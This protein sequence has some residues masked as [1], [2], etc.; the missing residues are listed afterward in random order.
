MMNDLHA[1]LAILAG[2]VLVLLLAADL[3]SRHPPVST[4]L[5]ATLVGLA[6]GPGGAGFFAP[7]SCDPRLTL[8]VL[9]SAAWVT[10]AISLMSIA[11]ELPQGYPRR[12]WR[13]LATM[14]GLVMP[15]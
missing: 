3:V 15:L 11:L 12:D 6:M 7:P 1:L 10:L 9:E 14:I 2:V 8:E 4:A 5:L 13:S